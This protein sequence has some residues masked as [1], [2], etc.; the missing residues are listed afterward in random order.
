LKQNRLY[1]DLAYLWP[2]VSPPEEYALEAWHL[3]EALRAKL[4]PGRHTLLELGVGG[5]HIL[6]H[7]ASEFQAIAVDISEQMLALSKQLNPD[8]EHHLGDMR[9]VRLG[10]TFQGVLVH[11][12]ICYMLSEDDLRAVFATARAHLEPGGVFIVAP[13]WFRETFKG[14]AV[15]HWINQKDALEVTFIEYVHDPDPSDTTI[16]SIFFFIFQEDGQLRIEQD[17]HIT[18]LFPL[19]TW[20]RLMRDARF[21]VEEIR[22]PACEGGYAGNILI[23]V[24]M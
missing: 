21:E 23:G 4:G 18:G 7:L 17:R 8:V 11:D 15:H 20:L 12:A 5:G 9:H 19:E 2:I 3:R 14:T 16:E 22:H 6:S 10:R 24:L 13:D 1:D